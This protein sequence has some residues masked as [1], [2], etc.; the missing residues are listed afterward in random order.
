MQNY[1]FKRVDNSRLYGGNAQLG[2]NSIVQWFVEKC[3]NN[4]L[5]HQDVWISKL[6]R[7]ISS[8]NENDVI[9]DSWW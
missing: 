3:K 4:I 1:D 5:I 8:E 9:V 6:I 2:I 7:N